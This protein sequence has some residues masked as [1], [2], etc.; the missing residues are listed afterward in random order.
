MV[1]FGPDGGPELRSVQ[2]VNA[3][4][5]MGRIALEWFRRFAKSDRPAWLLVPGDWLNDREDTATLDNPVKRLT[6]PHM[7]AG[8][9]V[10]RVGILIDDQNEWQNLL[11]A[12]LRP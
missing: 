12:H 3:R 7:L 10:R 1:Y 5:T 4:F 2:D 11:V 6:S 8:Q 9:A